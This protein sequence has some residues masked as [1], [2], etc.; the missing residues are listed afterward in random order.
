[1]FNTRAGAARLILAALATT[2]AVSACGHNYG[3]APATGQ[4]AAPQTNA[5]GSDVSPDS[6]SV[7]KSLKKQV[8]IGSAVDPDNGAGNPYGLTVAPVTNG[9]FTKGDLAICNFNAKSNKQGTGESVVALHPK[10]GSKPLHVSSIK[11]LKGCDALALGGDDTIWAAS[12]VAND[13]PIISTTGDLI[14]NIKGNPFSQPWGQIFATPTSGSP[15]FYETNAHTGTI[16]RIN[17]GSS[18]TYD[19]IGAGFPVNHGKP[20][21]ALA[22]SGL[23]YDASSDT[24]YFVDGMNDT[25]VAFKDVSSI[26]DGGIV[27]QNNGMKF[28]GPSASDA[29]VVFSGKPLNGPISTALLPNGSIVA[30]NTLDPDGKNLMVEITPA[31]KLLDVRNV[32]KGAAGSIFGMVATG[33]AADTKIYFNDDNDNNL[34]VLER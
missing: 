8:V 25:L 4:A 34:Q 5:A 26:P 24:L 2:L 22:P 7:L 9:D 15:A 13:N 29:R 16:V 28:S 10:P 23:A 1:M 20:G 12:M 30:G 18:F 17:L 19:V 6:S 32:D 21:T 27:A 14:D 11:P 31:G 3:V 33:T